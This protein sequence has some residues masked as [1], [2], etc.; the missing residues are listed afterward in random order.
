MDR[1]EGERKRGEEGKV[2]LSRLTGD[3]NLG[4]GN[5]AREKFLGAGG[6]KTFITGMSYLSFSES[7][8]IKALAD[9]NLP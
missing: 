1:Q 3:R 6:W 4:G 5:V 2:T 7:C 9:S 8:D